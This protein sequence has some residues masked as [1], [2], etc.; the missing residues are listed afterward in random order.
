MFSA[1][2]YFPLSH[3]SQSQQAISLSTA[4]RLAQQRSDAAT[5]SPKFHILIWDE[6][7]QF[8]ERFEVGGYL[9]EVGSK[10]AYSLKPDVEGSDCAVGRFEELLRN[11]SGEEEGVRGGK[12]GDGCTGAWY[13]DVETRRKG[14]VVVRRKEE[15]WHTERGRWRELELER[16]F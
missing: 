5:S 10:I 13:L 7:G 8:H 11:A 3:A 1:A 12:G 15:W 16:F 2:D 4:R 6:N 14:K 9:G